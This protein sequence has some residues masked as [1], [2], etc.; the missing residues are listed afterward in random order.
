[1]TGRR[2]VLFVALSTGPS[3]LGFRE[4]GRHEREGKSLTKRESEVVRFVALGHTGR[5]IADQLQ[6]SHDT[7]RTHVR[8]AMIKTGSRSRAHLVANVL[9]DGLAL[10]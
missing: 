10:A 3:R 2:L 9:G 8:N 6:L 1:V 7:V 5:E 4:S